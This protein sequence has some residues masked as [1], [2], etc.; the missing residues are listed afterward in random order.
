MRI[1]IVDS[2]KSNKDDFLDID[3]AQEDQKKIPKPS[4][5]RSPDVGLDYYKHLQMITARKAILKNTRMS[6]S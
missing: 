4:S 2:Q 3:L 1:S 6:V 5:L